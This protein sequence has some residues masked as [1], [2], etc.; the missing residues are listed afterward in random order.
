MPHKLEL[1][2]QIKREL[3]DPGRVPQRPLATEPVV[4]VP[5]LS[6]KA[7]IPGFK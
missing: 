5:T 3:L 6:R 2:S 4:G 1:K 7:L